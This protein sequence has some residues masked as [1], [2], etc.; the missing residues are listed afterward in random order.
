M[1]R[2]KNHE[3]VQEIPGVVVMAVVR[4]IVCYFCGKKE[5]LRST[6]KAPYRRHLDFRNQL[7][8]GLKWRLDKTGER[9][10]Y[11]CETC[12]PPTKATYRSPVI[13][14]EDENYYSSELR[15]ALWMMSWW[16]KLPGGGTCGH[17]GR[18][19]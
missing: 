10:L 13:R 2:E 1:T 4:H 15:E 8:V 3:L 19:P 6:A 7:F 18:K 17:C 12:N 9:P 16:D 5:T 11:C 14:P